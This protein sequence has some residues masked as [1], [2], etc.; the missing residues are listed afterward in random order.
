MLDP[1]QDKTHMTDSRHA[2]G[3][4][5]LRLKTPIACGNSIDEQ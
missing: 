1:S 2:I 5:N 4:S 3:A